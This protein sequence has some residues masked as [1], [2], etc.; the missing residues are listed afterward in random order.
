MYN[1]YV[2]IRVYVSYLLY[3]EQVPAVKGVVNPIGAG[4]CVTGVISLSPPPP[5]PP[6]GGFA[7][8]AAGWRCVGGCVGV[9]GWLCV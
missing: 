9:W 3:G 6:P 7:G 2:S 8:P 5:P 1:L 4:D